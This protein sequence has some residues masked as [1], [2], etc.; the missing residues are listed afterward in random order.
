MNNKKAIETI[1]ESKKEIESWMT[2]AR[3]LLTGE[4]IDQVQE[5]IACDECCLGEW[6]NSD[7]DVLKGKIWFNELVALHE[8]SHAAYS[9]LYH[10]TLRIYNP[11]TYDQ[12]KQYFVHLETVS[13]TLTKKLDMAKEELGEMPEL[14]SLKIKEPAALN[15]E[16]DTNAEESKEVIIEE[17]DNPSSSDLD[18]SSNPV[19]DDNI[20][21]NS[22]DPINTTSETPSIEAQKAEILSDL[23]SANGSLDENLENNDLYRLIE[24]Q[25]RQHVEH[26]KDLLLL[27]I[28]QLD[29]RKKLI[30]QGIEQ[31]QKFQSL[32]QK[33]Q[34]Q[35]SISTSEKESIK[36]AELE[37]KQAKLTKLTKEYDLKKQELEQMEVVSQKLELKKTEEKEQDKEELHK[38]EQ[39]K[40]LIKDDLN[41]IIEEKESKQTELDELEQKVINAK[42]AIDK[43][44]K[45]QSIKDDELVQ[46]KEKIAKNQHELEEDDLKREQLNKQK[47]EVEELK[48]NDLK[49]L[50]E[51]QESIK[52]EI[53]NLEQSI[54]RLNDEKI[55]ADTTLTQLFNQLEEELLSKT[56]SLEKIETETQQ[57]QAKLKQFESSQKKEALSE[58][59]MVDVL[60]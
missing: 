55:K 43:L 26:N 54:I 14:Q 41:Q 39:Q 4:N 25:N 34:Q 16:I 1:E 21:D 2:H 5:P 20:S 35:L 23:N 8:N 12:L 52:H 10:E 3:L 36:Q 13:N 32:K 53:N 22:V 51:R 18:S 11:K 50:E 33:E 9:K 30:L 37:S 48:Q 60:E 58:D 28:K 19:I 17:L 49:K 15:S 44:E 59:K 45:K 42:Q 7:A 31:L 24:E 29:E 57:K 27:E 6:I 38:L 47:H 40:Q 46:L 56:R